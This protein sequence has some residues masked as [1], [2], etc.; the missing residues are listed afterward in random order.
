MD[1]LRRIAMHRLARKATP[2]SAL[3]KY[4]D[5]HAALLDQL[6][7]VTA[8]DWRLD[9]VRFGVRRSMLWHFQQ[10]VMHFNEHRTDI[11]LTPAS[12]S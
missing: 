10:P 5:G 7:L 12:T 11:D 9:T 1:P 8:E 3:Q 4:D 6:S 2:E